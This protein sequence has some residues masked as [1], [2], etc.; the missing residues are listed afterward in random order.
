MSVVTNNKLRYRILCKEEPSIPLFSQDWWLDITCGSDNWDVVL[1]EQGGKIVGSLPL[2]IQKYFGFTFSIQPLLTKTLGPWV[3]PRQ[4]KYAKL[5][6][7]QKQ[8]MTNLIDQ[9]PA[10]SHFSQNWHFENTNW[11]PFYWKGF[12]QT[13]RYTYMFHSLAGLDEIW[14]GID[15]KIRTDI[16]KATERFHLVA[17]DDQDIDSFLVLNKM[18]FER[19]GIGLPYS[20]SLVKRLHDEC[21]RRKCGKFWIAVDADGKHHAGVYL[22]WDNNCA[23][24]LMS[25]GDT[26][27]RNSGATSF[28]L[29]EAIKFSSTVT[30]KFDFEG[31]MFEPIERFFRGFGAEQVPYF[32]VSD[33]PSILYKVSQCCDPLVNIGRRLVRK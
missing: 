2:Y 5:L 21:Q 3:R 10:Y 4:T 22:V 12:H 16:R 6:A 23:Y 27:L 13:T 30:S 32:N 19:Q 33:T 1:V 31:S 7:Y 9:L 28:L 20:E 17:K 14:S 29:W 26:N 11:L 15:T 18:T 8:V 24:Y 25:G